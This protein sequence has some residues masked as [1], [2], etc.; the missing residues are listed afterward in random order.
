MHVVDVNVLLAAA[1]SDHPHHAIAGA[2]LG[3]WLSGPEPLGLPDTV[4]SG[5]VRIST[6]RAAFPQPLGP[7]DA[8]LF[9]N[10]LLDAPA[11]RLL[12]P[13]ARHWAIFRD[14]CERYQTRG[15]DVTD[16]FF[17]AIA[18]EQRATWVSFDHGF[19]R[20]R[21]LTWLNPAEAQ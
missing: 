17:A 13:G 9:V 8:W 6:S 3:G 7:S 14:L 16:A 11:A 10:R 1:S 15:N 21:E 4:L 12:S 2:K 5:F 20:F 18:I 19:A